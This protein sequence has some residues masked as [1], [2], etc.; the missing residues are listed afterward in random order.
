[1]NKV[2]IQDDLYNYVNGEW[3]EKAVIPADRARTGGFSDLD[4]GVEKILMQDFKDFSE[5]KIDTDIEEM[6]EAIKLYKKV[7]RI[8]LKYQSVIF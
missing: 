1:M 5:G 6:K 2:R 7:L 8:Q 4:Q 3:I